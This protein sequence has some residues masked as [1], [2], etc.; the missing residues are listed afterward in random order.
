MAHK[1]YTLEILT[2]EGLV[3]TGEVEFVSTRTETG[4]IGIYARHQPLL[5]LLAPSEL[6]VTLEGGT[7]R[8]F[9]QGE[10]YV[11]VSPDK[12]LILVEEAFDPKDLDVTEL[13]AK[14]E[15]AQAHVASSDE[16]TE[17]FKRASRDERRYKAFIEALD[18]SKVAA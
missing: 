1:P 11:Q 17:E 6:R 9:V 15:K 5:A 8:S 7:V 3:F 12:V 13:R 10:G 18:G 4:S 16:G 14:L 2:P